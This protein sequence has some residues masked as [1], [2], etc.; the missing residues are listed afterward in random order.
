M[1]ARFDLPLTP[2]EREELARRASGLSRRPAL[3]A[4]C[5]GE[6]PAFVRQDCAAC[7]LYLE[8][9]VLPLGL[10]RTDLTGL[11]EG[12]ALRGDLDGVLLWPTLPEG[13]GEAS[14]GASLPPGRALDAPTWR[15]ALELVLARAE[16]RK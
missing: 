2:E 15:E 5:L 6:L 7:G 3:A 16:Q 4:V 11:L 10:D 9:Y 1:T 14:T 12:L 8:Q 13:W